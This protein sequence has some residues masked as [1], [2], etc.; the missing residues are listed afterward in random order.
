MGSLAAYEYDHSSHIHLPTQHPAVCTTQP[1]VFFQCLF[2]FVNCL[3]PI[4]RRHKYYVIFAIMFYVSLVL[5]V[6]HLWPPY[7]LPVLYEE[8]KFAHARSS[9]KPFRAAPLEAVV[10]KLVVRISHCSESKPSLS[11]IGFF[12]SM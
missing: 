2:L 1:K 8:A 10:Y 7:S 11:S 9:A 6:S 5:P 12:S 3:F 4:F